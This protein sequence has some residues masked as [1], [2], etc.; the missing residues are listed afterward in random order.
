[1]RGIILIVI[2][3]FAASLRATAADDWPPV[4]NIPELKDITIDGDGG[5][6]KDQGFRIEVLAPADGKIVHSTE[7]DALV[8]LGWNKEGLLVLISVVDRTPVEKEQRDQLEQG[9]SVELFVEPDNGG[10]KLIDYVIASGSERLNPERRYRIDDPRNSDP[11]VKV[12]GRKTAAGYVIEALILNMHQGKRLPR[13]AFQIVINDAAPG[14]APR[15]YTWYPADDTFTH[16]EHSHHLHLA[17]GPSPPVTT[18]VAGVYENLRHSRITLL[19]HSG[20]LGQRIEVSPGPS[21]RE[22]AVTNSTQ[23]PLAVEKIG[24]IAD[25]TAVS[26][27]VPLPPLGKPYEPLNVY[28][29]SNIVGRLTPVDIDAK[30]RH[31][32]SNIDLKFNPAVFAGDAFPQCDFADPIHAHDL[33]GGGY[34]FK[35]TFYNAEHEPVE[36]PDKPGRYGAV[37][38]IT[39]DAGVSLPAR[40]V[41]LFKLKERGAREQDLDLHTNLP[42]QLGIDPQVVKEQQPALAEHLTE[43]FIDGFGAEPDAALLL[44]AL[45]ESKP[46]EGRLAGMNSIWARDQRWWLP[47]KR[48]LGRYKYKCLIDVPDHYDR[49]TT[50]FPVILFLHGSGERGDDVDEL[51]ASGL[52]SLAK[53]PDN[54]FIHILRGDLKPNWP[55]PGFI[56][57]SPQC[58]AG[59]WWS[60]QQLAVLLDDLERTYRVDP[61]RVYV[62]GLSMGGYGAWELAAEFAERFAAIAP[63]CGAGSPDDAPRLKNLPTWVFHGERDTVV[64]F[65]RSAEM[66]EALKKA[67]GRVRF[68]AYP[69]KG[70]DA[71]TATYSN[72]ELYGWLFDQKRGAPAEPPA[73]P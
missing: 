31:A 20:L 69:E 43:R 47:I 52:P 64:P 71:W 36:K 5:D 66:V 45:A 37:V 40:L 58:P 22:V 27:V 38:D 1:M 42:P 32:L 62:T 4:Y 11:A 67:G 26:I 60:A 7:F 41:T 48:K 15:R 44:A 59:E 6:W 57:V 2:V 35:T 23:F 16:P 68:T 33:I 12:A 49:V 61:D 10:P 25:R 65:Q 54:A 55:F 9:D 3:L 17:T 30:R 18:A 8:R 70:H 29:D 63:V 28:V 13:R 34:T 51:R 39:T 73:K 21:L 24:S 19:T 53:A 46:G 56:L 14:R 50:K 72:P